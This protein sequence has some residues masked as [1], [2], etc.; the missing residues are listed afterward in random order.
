MGG[1]KQQHKSLT[2]VENQDL[3]RFLSPPPSLGVRRTSHIL[4][5]ISAVLKTL[6]KLNEGSRR[7]NSVKT[8]IA[9]GEPCMKSTLMKT[10]A[11]QRAAQPAD[12]LGEW[13]NNEPKLVW[14]D[15]LNNV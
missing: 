6:R 14:G 2:R 3:C 15:I 12:S 7:C 11:L 9:T 1:D 10:V 8:V 4:K 5:H 13:T